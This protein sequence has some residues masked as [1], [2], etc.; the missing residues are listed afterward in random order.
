MTEAISKNINLG[1][2]FSDFDDLRLAYETLE[3]EID[4]L[5]A[6]KAELNED[7]VAVLDLMQSAKGRIIITGMGK[8]G[9][10]GRKIAAS[11]ASTGTPAFFIHP[12][13]ASHGDL[14]MLAK[15]DVVIAISN[16]GEAKELADILY[17]CKRFEIP[18]V[19]ITKNPQ[20]SLAIACDI[21]LK[22]PQS[23]EACPL[24]LAP[25]SSTTATLVL[26]DILMVAL[27]QR[28]HF[29]K[30]D[31]NQR[32]PGGKLG[33]I[34]QTISKIMH[35][36]AE[37]PL[38]DEEISMKTALIE[39]SSKRLGCVGFIDKEGKLSGIFTDGD[40]RRHLTGDL[41]EKKALEVMTKNPLTLS[42]DVFASEA[43]KIMNEKKITNLFVLEDSRPIG[44]VHIH[45]LLHVGV[46]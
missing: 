32:H 16:S 1:A 20:S 28:K 30:T 23:P 7:L 27:M 3:K 22:L 8:S 36:G 37:M 2:Q 41:L 21:V 43:I 29:S 45:D 14:G 10:I 39:M 19:G 26:G 9:I 25:T 40:L 38:L 15:D 6:L 35:K 17:Y 46:A 42:K 33:S 34:L 12:S 18:L 44:I 11:L 4:A 5:K 24:G 31:F 13:E